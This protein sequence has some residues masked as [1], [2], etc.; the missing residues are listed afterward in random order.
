MG[1]GIREEDLPHIF[2]RFY[3]RDESRR[4]D[5]D[6]SGLGLAIAHSIVEA[7]GGTVW[8]GRRNRGAAFIITFKD[9]T[10]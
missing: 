5:H 4:A 1:V 8:A 7:H 10:A 9:S 6:E 3:R 2:Y